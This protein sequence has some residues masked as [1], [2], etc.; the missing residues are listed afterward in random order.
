[1]LSRRLF[2]L[3]GL[4][5]ISPL[6]LAA[7]ASNSRKE[8]DSKPDTQIGPVNSTNKHQVTFG[9]APLIPCLMFFE[10]CRISSNKISSLHREKKIGVIAMEV[11]D[12]SISNQETLSVKVFFSNGQNRI[13]KGN[14]RSYHRTKTDGRTIFE[15]E[16][17]LL[18]NLISST[19]DAV[20]NSLR[21]S[22]FGGSL[23]AT[24]KDFL[25]LQEMDNL[26]S[27]AI[28]SIFHLVSEMRQ[29]TNIRSVTFDH[30][31]MRFVIS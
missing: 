19:L 20:F 6:F 11:D 27:I 4:V 13:L 7:C 17:V 5:G 18:K 24:R 26:E 21:T 31:Q 29:K 2:L 12:M 16:G 30:K 23:N 22:Q 1:M 15:R 28:G 25:R 10:E 14:P 3:N 8:A 9:V